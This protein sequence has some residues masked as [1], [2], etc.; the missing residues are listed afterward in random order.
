LIWLRRIAQVRLNFP[1]AF[2]E[3]FGGVVVGDSRHDDAVFAILPVGRRGKF[4]LGGKLKGVNDRR[5][6]AKFRPVLAG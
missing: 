3:H 5:I 4:A 2:G 1:D 6:S